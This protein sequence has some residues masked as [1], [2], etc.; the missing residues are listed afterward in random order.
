MQIIIWDSISK[1]E[2]E[3]IKCVEERKKLV[4]AILCV[5]PTENAGSDANQRSHA[6]TTTTTCSEKE[7]RR[8]NTR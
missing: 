4:N 1:V 5:M 6:F 3:K 8:T 2:E 7:T